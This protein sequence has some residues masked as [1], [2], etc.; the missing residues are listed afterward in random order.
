[1]IIDEN[2]FSYSQIQQ[3]LNQTEQNDSPPQQ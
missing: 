2:Q 1:M 3:H